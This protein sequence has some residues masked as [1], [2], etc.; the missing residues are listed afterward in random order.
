MVETKPLDVYLKKKKKRFSNNGHSRFGLRWFAHHFHVILSLS[1]NYAPLMWKM[2]LNYDYC[3]WIWE[4]SF[5]LVQFLFCVC[6]WVL[7]Q[8]EDNEPACVVF[9]W[10]G[11]EARERRGRH[12]HSSGFIVNET[13][14]T[15]W[16]DRDRVSQLSLCSQ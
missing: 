2:V 10:G 16:R 3:T 8:C 9:S 11:I 7:D 13:G 12:C 6:S 5:L 15:T 14:G 4:V 1:L